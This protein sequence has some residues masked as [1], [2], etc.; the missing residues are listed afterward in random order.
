MPRTKYSGSFKTFTCPNCKALYQMIRVEEGPE[1]TEREIACHSC[2]APL[3]GR[4]GSSPS[5]ISFCGPQNA[6]CDALP[7]RNNIPSADSAA[8]QDSFS[9][10]AAWVVVG[11]WKATP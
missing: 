11:E 10:S 7:I 6:R 8:A 4:E 3:S 9:S 2:G 5:N 1:I